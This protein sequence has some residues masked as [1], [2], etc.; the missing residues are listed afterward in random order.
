MSVSILTPREPRRGGLGPGQQAWCRKHLGR[1]FVDSARAAAQVQ[2]E[3]EQSR[4]RLARRDQ[5]LPK[6]PGDRRL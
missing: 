1:P 2:R 5:E 4:A 6:Q 3:N